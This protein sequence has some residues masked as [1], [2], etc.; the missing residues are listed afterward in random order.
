M[1]T[2]SKLAV[3]TLSALF[4]FNVAF[5]QSRVPY[6]SRQGSEAEAIA[7]LRAMYFRQDYEG[8]RVEGKRLI[9]VFP[10]SLPLRAWFV[11]NLAADGESVDARSIADAMKATHPESPWSWFAAA[12]WQQFDEERGGES[13]AASEKLLSL[14][15]SEPDYLWLRALVLKQQQKYQEAIAFVDKN[16]ASVTHPAEFLVV[17]ACA[18]AVLS[19]LK[20]SETN[21]NATLDA[22]AEA[23]KEDN[24]N[25]NAHYYLAKHL[26]FLKR[27]ADACLQLRE[28]L[29][30]SRD[31][32]RIHFLFW[33]AAMSRADVPPEKKQQEVVTDIKSLVEWRGDY[34]EALVDAI[35]QY[36][37]LN[38]KPEQQA[39]EERLL[40]L[41]RTSKEAELVLAM[42][43]RN[44]RDRAGEGE[45]KDAGLK[46]TYSDML[47]AFIN[48]SP[49]HNEEL[50]GEAY[51][52]LFFL[53]RD[54]YSVSN[55][56][57]VAI[58]DGMVKHNRHNINICFALGAIALADRQ[59]ALD[60]AEAVAREGI[61]R[62][63]KE[64]ARKRNLYET[65]G[66]Y[67]VA[68]ERMAGLMR[69]A[70]GWVIFKAG[71][72]VEAE[73]ELLRARD[74]NPDNVSILNHLG[75]LYEAKGDLNAAEG[76]Y[77]KGAMATSLAANPND[78]SL[79][80]LY[81]KR[82]GD[83]AGYDEYLKNIANLDR[84]RRMTAVLKSR[85]SS[86]KSMEPFNLEM[87]AAPSLASEKIKGKVAVINFWGVWCGACVAEM[88][89][90]QKLSDKY[91]ADSGVAI[92]AIDND[93]DA[94]Y[95]R[96]WMQKHNYTFNVLMDNG[97]V[98]K[99]GINAFPTTWFID[100]EGRIAFV[101]TGWSEKLVEE[102]SWRIEALKG[103]AA[104]E[105]QT[106]TESVTEV[107]SQIV[108]QPFSVSAHVEMLPNSS[109]ASANFVVVINIAPGYHINANKPDDDYL[110]PTTVKPAPG[111]G[112][113][114]KDP[115]YPA[116]IT[117]VER[118]APK[119][120]KV[121][122][123]EVVIK[124]PFDLAAGRQAKETTV[125]AE[126]RAQACNSENCLP[127]GRISLSVTTTTP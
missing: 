94:D 117:V 58:V 83:S 127:P 51:I 119:P 53:T 11:L 40:R 14:M 28:A 113:L 109:K 43:F 66:D 86:R 33:T 18:L 34:P 48:R 22:F 61:A 90:F 20:P 2:A 52:E 46:K 106:R 74:L 99:I 13:I 71:R 49:H 6:I 16:R 98:S 26:I 126:L 41:Y 102:F 82:H 9:A 108:S 57:F 73:S 70:L 5:S 15:P 32:A 21:I 107:P 7:K 105:V 118:F 8:A 87:I 84:D 60:K 79:R 3:T 56:D 45:I 62:A 42:R 85:L 91:K 104:A 76:F 37:S 30:L 1:T 24:A 63:Q 67:E 12:A 77:I 36:D 123:G 50:V 97:Y 10:K 116:P 31:A 114:W 89:D 38:L 81:Y 35:I 111:N 69:N 65:E 54:D 47:W 29:K 93:S 121:Y 72:A 115:I 122:D 92:L 101:K 39:L 125:S 4:A 59:A 78:A 55:A 68:Q 25:V 95:T 110:I 100:K 112:V 44:F 64:V 103:E 19:Y 17:R 27:Y 124:V 23:L 88:P 80:A 75:Q 96:A 120:L